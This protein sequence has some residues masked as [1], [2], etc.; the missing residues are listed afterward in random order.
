MSIELNPSELFLLATNGL[1]LFCLIWLAI[2]CVPKLKGYR[3]MVQLMTADS[4][5]VKTAPELIQEWAN[6]REKWP[7]GSPKWTAYTNRLKEAGYFD[8]D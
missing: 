4:P 8:E 6:N 5:A 3:R 7:E 1:T 2:Y